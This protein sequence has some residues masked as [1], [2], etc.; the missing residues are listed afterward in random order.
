MLDK[1]NPLRVKTDDVYIPKYI[2]DAGL[3]V[4]MMRK[5]A[6]LQTILDTY[7]LVFNEEAQRP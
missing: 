1:K 4:E 7:H 3:E 5:S 6:R 2:L